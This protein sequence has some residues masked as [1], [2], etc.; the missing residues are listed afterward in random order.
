MNKKSNPRELKLKEKI[1]NQEE[2]IKELLREIERKNGDLG[3][4][5]ETL[6]Q[7]KIK[8]DDTNIKLS[9]EERL[10]NVHTKELMRQRKLTNFL[11]D[12]KL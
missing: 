7:L 1:S 2:N 12:S 9:A 5:S 8:L 11:I 6:A 3:I 4:L 10:N